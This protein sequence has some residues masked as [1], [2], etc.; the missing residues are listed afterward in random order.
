MPAPSQG[1]R[2]ISFDGPALDATCLSELLILEDIAGKWAWDHGDD[3]EGGDVRVGEICDIVGGT[4][5]GGFYAILFS[6]NMTIGQVITSHKILQNIVFASDEWARKDP[7]KCAAVLKT[8]LEQL[9]KEVGLTVDLDGPFLSKDSLKCYVCILDD[10]HVGSARSLRNYRV[11]SSKSPRC[12]IREAIHVTLADG[13]HLPPTRVQDEQFVSASLGF[14][15]PSYE[16]MKELPAAFPKSSELA[17]FVNLGAGCSKLVRITASVS[18][19]EQAKRAQEAEA[20]AQNLIALCGGLGPCYFRLSVAAEIDV[21]MP[22][23]ID[24]VLRV[25]KSL[26]VRYLEE[27]NIGVHLDAVVDTLAKRHGVVLLERLGSLAARDGK[28]RLNAHVEAV[29]DHVVHMKKTMDDEFY[30]KM[31]TWLTPIDQTAKLDS[32][33]RT[34]TASTCSWLWDSPRVVEWRELGGIFWCYA[35]MGAGKTMIMYIQ[36]WLLFDVTNRRLDRSYV[37]ETLMKVPDECFVAYYYFEFTNPSTLSEEALFRSLIFQLS[38][39]SYTASRRLYEQH[40]NGS[41]QPQLSTL[42]ESLRELVTGAPLPAYIIIDALDELPLAQ[43]KYLVESLLAFSH[44][45]AN[46]IHI[47]TTSRDELDIHKAFSEKVPLDFSVEKEMVRNDIIVFVEKELSAEKWTFWPT[48]EVEKMRNI[49]IDKADGMHVLLLNGNPQAYR[50]MIRF[51]MVACQVEVLNQTQSTEDMEQALASLPATLGDT[52]LYILNKI[53]PNL[54][55]R[56]HT[57]LCILSTALGPIPVTELS[58]LLAVELGDPTDPTNL[59]AYRKNLLFHEPQG[60]IG[61]GTALIRRITLYRQTRWGSEEEEALQL[62]HASVKEYLLQDTCHWFALNDQLT[63]ETV[64]RACLAL[65]IHNED[66]KR[67][68]GNV[69]IL[70]TA[71]N[72]WRHIPSNHSAQLLSQQEKLFETFPWPRTPGSEWLTR[73][74]WPHERFLKSPLIFAAAASLEQLLLTMLKRSFRWKFED[75]DEAMDVA[76][77]MRSSAEVFNALIEQGGNVNSTTDDGTPILQLQT[78]SDRLYIA[79]ILVENG[80]DVNTVGGKYGSALQAAAHAGAP[81]IVKFLIENGADVNMVGGLHA[82]A[83]HAAAFQGSLDVVKLLVGNGADVNMVGGLYKWALQAAAWAG[84]LDVVEFLVENGAD[85]NMAGGLYG[86]PLQAAACAKALDVVKFLVENGADVN[87]V[88][89]LH[90]SVLRAAAS[91]N[92]LDVTEFLVENGADVNMVREGCGSALQAAAYTGALDVGKFLVENG[93]DVNMVGGNFTPALYAASHV[94]DLDMVGF[95]AENGADMNMVGGKYG[96]ALQ[97]AAYVG[98]LDVVKFFVENGADLNVVGGDYRSTLEAV[99]HS[100]ILSFMHSRRQEMMKFLIA[101]GAT[102][103][104]GTTPLVDELDSEDS[105]EGY[106]SDSSYSTQ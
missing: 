81:D 86:S 73:N 46:G 55:T 51:R 91:R 12:S 89:G 11:R 3:R 72:W 37:V 94:A 39:A 101:H 67:T 76:S 64:A 24:E 19:E 85:V 31:K 48:H 22:K 97:A 44:L 80:A 59:P 78:H 62:S 57:L 54:R 84:A 87:M 2:V 43:R 63:N 56:A 96:S 104:D 6:L 47:M 65:L 8:A 23:S 66:P 106:V 58:A 98:A 1:I 32:C 40:R 90:G 61:L 103:L 99:E 60:I 77:H 7:I 38:H 49:L 70:H 88:G 92:A 26:T 52:Y 5:I 79:R 29:H 34:R 4:G 20:V 95:L 21:S 17:C 53:S 50:Y 35:G 41:L 68:S 14:A 45:T 102:R 69:K 71:N 18:W 25:V 27:A 10:L 93:A 28:A 36:L 15:N 100:L 83:L 82:S 75:L 9:V 105:S 13:T 16:L 33:I 74:I 30:S 42:H